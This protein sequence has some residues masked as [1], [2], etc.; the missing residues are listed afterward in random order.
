MLAAIFLRTQKKNCIS[1]IKIKATSI[2]PAAFRPGFSM[3]ER[4]TVDIQ[5]KRYYDGC[6]VANHG[7]AAFYEYPEG[8][9]AVPWVAGRQT[10]YG[11]SIKK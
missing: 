8:H 5:Q 2:D 4:R 7:S 1:K 3:P 11:I 6:G 10:V 9:R